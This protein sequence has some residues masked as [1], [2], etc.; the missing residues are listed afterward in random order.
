MQSGLVELLDDGFLECDDGGRGDE[1]AEESP[2]G[3]VCLKIFDLATGVGNVS[4][5][6][7]PIAVSIASRKSE[8]GGSPLSF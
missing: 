4:S 3:E 7:D 5:S 6:D 8:I 1:G 2:S